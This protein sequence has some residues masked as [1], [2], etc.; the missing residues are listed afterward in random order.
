[1][2]RSL[3]YYLIREYG[4]M[5]KWRTL[6]YYLERRYKAQSHSIDGALLRAGEPTGPYDDWTNSGLVAD[7]IADTLIEFVLVEY[8][9]S[10]LPRLLDGFEQHDSWATLAPS[11]FGMTAVE[12]EAAWHDYLE[13]EYP[14]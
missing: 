1:M 3:E 8:G 14:G 2:T 11:V 6:T 12:F 10:H 9:Y 7:E 13:A 5:S 4:F